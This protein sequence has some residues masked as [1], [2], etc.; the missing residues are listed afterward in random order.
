MTR[1]EREAKYQE[2][3]ERIFRDFSESKSS[4]GASGDHSANLSRS[5]SA[6]GRKKTFRQKT[7]HDDTFEARSQ[8]NP[9][10]PGTQYAHEP[11]PYSVPM[12]DGAYPHQSPY[13]VGAGVSPTSIG[14]VSTPNGPAFPA[15]VNV[16]S[17]PQYPMPVSPQM[18]QNAPWQS[19]GIPQQSNYPGYTSMSQSQGIMGPQSSARS[20][21][22][23][24]YDIP[25]QHTPPNWP[26][27]TYSGNYTRSANRCQPQVHW[28]TYSPQP[29]PSNQAQYSYV[30]Y[31]GQAVN[32][33]MQNIPTNPH[34]PPVS[35]GRS[36]FNPQTRSFVPGATSPR[37]PG[38]PGQPTMSQYL[39]PHHNSPNHWAGY[40]DTNKQFE[41]PSSPSQPPGRIGPTGNRDSIAKWG[42]PAHLPPKPPPSQFSSDF[43]LRHQNANLT[44]P[45]ANNSMTAKSGPLVVSGG[46]PL[47]KPN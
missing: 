21:P 19:S 47:A 11:T 25:Y 44:Q 42:T 8:F 28:P 39:G 40:L 1:E 15:P 43:D 14:Y 38:M 9:Y 17:V 32:L 18:S 46:A 45:Y 31:P 23:T 3:R 36:G 22:M 27:T 4:D 33:Q 7:P 24:N 12:S 13:V 16:N 34:P 6:S 29:M 35:F 5:S 37:H 26:Q 20:S 2:A 41:S 10:Y 30:Q